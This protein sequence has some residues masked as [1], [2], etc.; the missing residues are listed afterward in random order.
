MSRW[1]EQFENHPFQ[2]TWKEIIKVTENVDVDDS[3]VVTSVED[4]ARLKKVI[5]YLNGLLDACDPELIPQST[6]QNFHTQTTPCLQQI[7]TYQSNR[8]I[9]HITQANAHL[10]NLLTYLRPYQVVVGK[11]AKSASAS[12]ITYTKTINSNLTSFQ[13]Q[14]R[15]ILIEIG[16]YKDKA[17]SDAEESSLSSVR[18]KELA[19]GYFDD[20]EEESLSSKINRFE[21]QL[22]ENYEKIKSY[23]V[24]LIDGD[25]GN[26]SIAS[27]IKSALKIAEI[28]SETIKS[29]M[30]D[31][32]TKLSDFKGYYTDVFG[33]KNDEGEFEGGLKDEITAR[34]KHLEEFKKQQEIKYKTLNDEI[35]S[36]LPGATSAGLASAYHE[37]KES[38]DT[39][40]KNYSK[41]FYGSIT[42]LMLVSFI[43][44]TQ[45]LGLFF[46]KFVDVSDFSKLT[47]NILFKLPIIIP[48]L[49]LTLFVSKRRSE[50]LRLQQE[51]AHKEALAKSYQSFKI[52]IEALEQAD[53]ELMKKLLNSTIDAV[54]KNASD[55]LDKNHGDKTPVHE[56]VDGLISSIEKIKK[57][58]L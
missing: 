23:K 24:E 50:A 56:G 35:E 15:S 53:P 47:S 5:T 36:L 33:L 10:D 43:S 17:L 38:F 20:T 13:D 12:F 16:E 30:N 41:L 54:S 3:T 42:A 46:I 9:A 26:E 7:T 45:E 1:I 2:T 55:T 31:V 32:K 18:I 14:A 21:T 34:E 4:V 44:I 49:W 40:I 22:E 51:Y 25:S 39:P 29:L 28:D 8:N 6:W 11:A 19:A 58:F 37:L 27:E 52:Q 57:V 48:I